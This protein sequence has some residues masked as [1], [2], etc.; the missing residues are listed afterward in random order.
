M[1]RT[2]VNEAA[3]SG[4]GIGVLSGLRRAAAAAL[5]R[6]IPQFNGADNY[7]ALDTPAA[8]GV[9]DTLEFQF[10]SL[11]A[12]VLSDVFDGVI[13]F[14][15]AEL[16]QLTTCTATFDGTPVA[17]GASISS[18]LD[19]AVYTGIL[20]FTGAATITY[21]G[22]SGASTNYLKG[23][24]LSFKTTI[25]SVETAYTLDSDGLYEL[26]DG[27]SEGAELFTNGSFDSNVDGYTTPVG[28]LTHDTSGDGGRAK[29]TN[30][31]AS[32]GY[33][34]Q[35][36][37]TVIGERYIMQFTTDKGTSASVL[38]RLGDAPANGSLYNI[39]QT[40]DGDHDVFFTATSTTTYFTWFTNSS[41]IGVFVYIDELSSKHVTKPLIY[42]NFDS[43]DWHNYKYDSALSRWDYQGSG[44]AGSQL[45]QFEGTATTPLSSSITVTGS[46][47]EM[48]WEGLWVAH[49]TSGVGA[50]TYLAAPDGVPMRCNIEVIDNVTAYSM[51]NEKTTVQSVDNALAAFA[52]SVTRVPRVCNVTLTG[53]SIPTAAGLANKAIIEAEGGTVLVDS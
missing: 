18:Y 6:L 9:G 11:D 35:A 4:F 50:Y 37:D 46:T 7:A 13:Q 14:D 19:G 23:H 41:T 12:G 47:W 45:M 53:N 40:V 49:Y 22:Q 2:A 30:D 38:T 3:I 29:L 16:L 5:A 36:L 31:T 24:I 1:I 21:V 25:S 28:V 8:M 51:I 39:A 17:D 42:T 15:A 34:Y 27:E 48:N 44:T 26:P 32:S 10:A 20:T 33:S 52:A 43:V